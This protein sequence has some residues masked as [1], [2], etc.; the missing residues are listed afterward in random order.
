MKEYK[1]YYQ[2]DPHFHLPGTIYSL[3][4]IENTHVYLGTVI[5]KDIEKVFIEMQGEVWSP[6]GEARPFIEAAGLYHTSMSVGDIVETEDGFFSCG[7]FGWEFL[8]ERR[9]I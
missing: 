4:K 7:T 3:D 1:V 5:A 8:G 9:R 2:K 6:R